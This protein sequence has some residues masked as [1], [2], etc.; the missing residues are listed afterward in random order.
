MAYGVTVSHI[1]R[2]LWGFGF[3]KVSRAERL[4]IIL[5]A[6]A[7]VKEYESVSRKDGTP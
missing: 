2:G 5:E 1:R 7:Q 6:A 3:V 4:E